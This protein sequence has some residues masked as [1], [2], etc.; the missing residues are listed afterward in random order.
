MTTLRERPE[1]AFTAQV[2]SRPKHEDPGCRVGEV[3][4]KREEH[5]K[6]ISRKSLRIG[7][8]QVAQAL[9]LL[10]SEGK[11][12]VR[13]VYTVLKRRET[14][15]RDIRERLAALGDDGLKLIASVR[16]SP[17]ATRAA[18]TTRSMR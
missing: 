18:W 15:L 10:V 4:F 9:H 7:R 5:L 12:A 17:A 2:L 1:R 8:E 16:R 6:R 13:E 3:L 11:V 14:L